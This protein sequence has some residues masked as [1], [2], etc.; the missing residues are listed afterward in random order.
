MTEPNEKQFQMR[1]SD[2]FLRTIDDWRRKQPDLPSRAEAVRR[3][4]D[5]GLSQNQPRPAGAHKGA[6]RAKELAGKEV[7]RAS[8]ASATHEQRQSRKRRILKGPA[9]FRHL[10]KDLPKRSG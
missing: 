10:R 9:E 2:Q 4:V 8:D 6:S 5:A 1:V 3:L 7:D